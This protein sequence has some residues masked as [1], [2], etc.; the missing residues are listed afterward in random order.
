MRKRR[1][2]KRSGMA[3]LA[4]ASLLAGPVAAACSS[5]PTYDDWAATDGAA[6]RINLDDVQN[7]YSNAEIPDDVLARL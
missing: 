1:E 2:F 4:A 7:V 3:A 5:G 6:G